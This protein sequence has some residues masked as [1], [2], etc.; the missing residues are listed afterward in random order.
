MSA[1]TANLKRARTLTREQLDSL[2]ASL[3]EDADWCADMCATQGDD[4]AEAI[5]AG[6]RDAIEKHA[7]E[8]VRRYVAAPILL[9][10]LR[11]MLDLHDFDQDVPADSIIGKA[12]AAVAAAKGIRP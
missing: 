8:I 10:A 2:L 1:R 9:D 4:E 3:A 12:R 5:Y 7:P 11:W 6:E